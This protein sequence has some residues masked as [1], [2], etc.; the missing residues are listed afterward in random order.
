LPDSQCG[1]AVPASRPDG[2]LPSERNKGKMP[3]PHLNEEFFFER[4]LA[5]DVRLGYISTSSVCIRETL[6][7]YFIKQDVISIFD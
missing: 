7:E 2:I 4:F 5:T 3:S 6:K 1:E